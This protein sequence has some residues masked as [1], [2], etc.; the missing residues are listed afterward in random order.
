M[1]KFTSCRGCRSWPSLSLSSCS[2]PVPA[3]FHGFWW[4]NCSAPVLVVSPLLWRSQPI[5]APTSSCL[6]SSC[7]SRSVADNLFNQ[8][9]HE[10]NFFFF[11]EKRQLQEV[12]EGYVFLIFTVLLL[13]FWY[14]T[15]RRVPETKGKSIDEIAAMFRQ[16]AYQIS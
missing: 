12:M 4:L 15:Y 1:N 11:F 5:G 13:I 9:Q 3:R 7:R 10:F 6:S 8:F 2:L 14:F 16:K